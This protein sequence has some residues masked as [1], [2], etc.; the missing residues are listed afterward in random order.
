MMSETGHWVGSL[1]H[2]RPGHGYMLLRKGMGEVAFCYPLI[3]GSEQEKARR[4]APMAE[5]SALQLKHSHNMPIIATVILADGSEAL[6][7]AVLR[8]YE[9]D[10]LVGEAVADEEGR[11]FLMTSADDGSTLEFTVS[12][13][14][15][16]PHFPLRASTTAR[17][18]SSLVLGTPDHPFLV[19]F[20]DN[21]DGGCPYYD[22]SGR[23][24]AMDRN[25]KGV[26]ISRDKRG[27]WHKNLFK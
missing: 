2:M 24:V 19:T 5:T 23:R 13:D 22:L 1:T 12:V 18:N 26:V 4:Q 7:G 14:G 15:I 20:R 10:E 8:A 16:S 25:A 6:P 11:F 21:E 9:G 17:Y 27:K 3:L